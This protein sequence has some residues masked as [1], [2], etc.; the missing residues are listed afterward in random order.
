ML[1]IKIAW[2]NL[3]RNRRRT[4][5]QL[6]AIIGG[7]FLSVFYVIFVGGF[8]VNTLNGGVRSGSGHIGLYHERY[9]DNPE[10]ADTVPASVLVPRLEQDPDVAAVYPRLHAAGLLRSSRDNRP[11]AVTGL[12]FEREADHNPMLSPENLVAGHLPTTPNGI[13]IGQALARELRVK[14]GKKVVWVTQDVHGAIVSQLFRVSGVVDT[15]VKALDAR[16]I[17]AR[18]DTVA[19]LLGRPGSAHEIAVMLQSPDRIPSALPHLQAIAR[20]ADASTRAYAWDDAMPSLAALVQ[21][22]NA[23]EGF[24]VVILFAMVAL[25]TMNTMLMSVMERTREFGMIRAMG[26][27]KG[28]VRLMVLV[29]GLLLGVLGTGIGVALAFLVNLQT[30]TSGIDLSKAY[31]DMDMGG[32]AMDLLVKTVWDWRMTLVLTVGMLVLSVLA[33]LYPARWALRIRPADAMRS[34]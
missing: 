9:L 10:V 23:K 5:I 13:V 12:D 31:G 14:V 16:M 28:S 27:S 25:G 32:I 24:T 30:A 26:V 11:V 33:S 8:A 6:A 4:G 29:E 17:V 22:S 34:Y 19:T 3:W 15:R 21:A 1:W 2:R 18:R 7:M 20:A